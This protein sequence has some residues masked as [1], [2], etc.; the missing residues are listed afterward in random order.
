VPDVRLKEST[1]HQRLAWETELLGFVASGRPLE[2]RD[3]I[4]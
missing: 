2:A 4:A 3:V 1:R